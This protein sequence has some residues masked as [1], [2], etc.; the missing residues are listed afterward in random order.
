MHTPTE[1]DEWAALIINQ[2]FDEKGVDVGFVLINEPGREN[3]KWKLPSG[4]KQLGETPLSTAARENKEETGLEIPLKDYRQIPAGLK[5][6]RYPT[7]HWSFLFLARVPLLQVGLIHSND[8]GNEGEV[9]RFF[10]HEDF[11]IEVHYETVLE[12]HLRKMRQAQV[13]RESLS[14]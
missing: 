5:W 2:V 1:E 10:T 12:P 8:P 9:P 3:A 13:L 7:E 6:N 14:A 4:R 11:D